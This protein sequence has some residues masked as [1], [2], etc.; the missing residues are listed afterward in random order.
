[1]ED[2][3]RSISVPLAQEDFRRSLANLYNSLGKVDASKNLLSDDMKHGLNLLSDDDRS[4]DYEG[5]ERIANVLMHAKD[6]LNALTAFSLIGPSQRYSYENYELNISCH[7]LCR[8]KFKF[9][10]S[11]WWCKICN[12]VAFDDEC[13]KS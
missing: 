1:M 2:L 10:E 8:R 5:Y 4:N 11:L 13:F 9:G 12:M 7:G 3:L 6:D